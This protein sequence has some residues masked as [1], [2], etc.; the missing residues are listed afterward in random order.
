MPRRVSAH[1]A[2][3]QGLRTFLLF[4]VLSATITLIDIHQLSARETLILGSF[5][6]YT[7]L[8][9]LWLNWRTHPQGSFNDIKLAFIDAFFIS[10]VIATHHI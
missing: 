3:E 9:L 1:I 8:S 5:G 7:I 4:F 2:Q 10:T 6:V